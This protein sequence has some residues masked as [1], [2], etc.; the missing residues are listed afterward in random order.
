ME[1]NKKKTC[2]DC[3]NFTESGLKIHHEKIGWFYVGQCFKSNKFTER[4]AETDSA[5]KDY[6]ENKE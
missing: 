1:N 4:V 3:Y 2:K 6:E 5:C